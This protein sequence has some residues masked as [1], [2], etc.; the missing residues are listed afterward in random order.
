MLGHTTPSTLNHQMTRGC[1]E[2]DAYHTLPSHQQP[3]HLSCSLIEITY[4]KT[5]RTKIHIMYKTNSITPTKV[6]AHMKSLHF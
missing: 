4:I 5:K 2:N 1:D 6:D 3:K